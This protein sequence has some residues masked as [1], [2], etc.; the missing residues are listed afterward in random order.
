MYEQELTLFEELRQGDALGVTQVLTKHTMV[1]AF[2]EIS[3]ETREVEGGHV[4][5]WAVLCSVGALASAFRLL[6]P[7]Y[8]TNHVWFRVQR[9][10]PATMV[11]LNLRDSGLA[12]LIVCLRLRC[13]SS[14]R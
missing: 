6:L 3:L 14:T 4:V 1:P 8:W 11:F 12:A 7:S 13:S 10:M 9:R 5:P 2:N